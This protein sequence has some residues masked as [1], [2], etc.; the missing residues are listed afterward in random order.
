MVLLPACLMVL[1][2][3]AGGAVLGVASLITE[4]VTLTTLIIVG[5]VA[6]QMFAIVQMGPLAQEATAARRQRRT[7]AAGAGWAVVV[8]ASLLLVSCTFMSKSHGLPLQ[9]AV[10]LTVMAGSATLY[11]GRTDFTR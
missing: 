5:S 10:S 11:A 8:A 3:L 1:G 7:L 4:R 6:T 9:L 2:A